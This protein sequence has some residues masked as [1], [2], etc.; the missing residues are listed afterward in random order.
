MIFPQ[1]RF[2]TLLLYFSRFINICRTNFCKRNTLVETHLTFL[3]NT[4]KKRDKTRISC[5]YLLKILKIS[6]LLSLFSMWF[7]YCEVTGFVIK[8]KW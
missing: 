7:H 3:K 4:E 6:I 8:Q 5:S 1:A 2:A